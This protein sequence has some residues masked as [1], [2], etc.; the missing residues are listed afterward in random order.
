M[1]DLYSWTTQARNGAA[2]AD[3][4]GFTNRR[5]SYYLN[6]PCTASATLSLASPNALRD[7]TN[8]G[9][10][11]GVHEMKI[12]RDGIAQETVFR[13]D[14]VGINFDGDRTT[15][16]LEWSGIMNYLADGLILG[17][18]ARWTSTTLPW[19]WINNFQSRTGAAFGIT[20][21]TT[22]G[23]AT[24]QTRTIQQ[25]AG[26]LDEIV[27]LSESGTG[28]DFQIDASRAFNLWYPKRA[29]NTIYVDSR[30]NV[31]GFDWI[32]SAGAGEI[33]TDVR[34]FGGSGTA[35]SPQ[36]SSDATART[37]YGRREASITY[38]VELESATVTSGNLAS[39]ASAAIAERKNPLIIPG[40]KIDNTHPS[41][42]WGTYDVGSTVELY[43][44]V[45]PYAVIDDTYRI[46]AIHVEPDDNDN[47]SIS[48]D[49]FLSV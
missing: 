36:A 4:T 26:L 48:L 24:S 43:L 35:K 47:E 46:G 42:A 6:R 40:V 17:R 30:V 7:S 45:S 22:T 15:L 31:R 23:T 44:D 33:V 14:S 29:T 37:T 18:Q 25:D 1:S 21:G 27:A 10:Q 28:F 12:Y 41:L 3:I 39:Y 32:E 13:L 9:L 19:T 8:G 20:S 49:L 11:P 16:D 2:I 5:I 38:P 34:C